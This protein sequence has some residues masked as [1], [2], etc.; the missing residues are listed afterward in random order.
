MRVTLSEVFDVEVVGDTVRVKPTRPVELSPFWEIRLDAE[1]HRE[2][3]VEHLRHRDIEV[4]ED[5]EGTLHV[6]GFAAAEAR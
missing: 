2:T 6:W 3:N 1:L 5:P 4:D